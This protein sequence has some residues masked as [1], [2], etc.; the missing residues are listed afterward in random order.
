MNMQNMTPQQRKNR[1]DLLFK[2]IAF[3]A[4]TYQN[5]INTRDKLIKPL[6]EE[7]WE[8]TQIQDKLNEIT[9]FKD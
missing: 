8:I 4:E 7:L 6:S 5:D 9:R 1:V 3:I 2:Q